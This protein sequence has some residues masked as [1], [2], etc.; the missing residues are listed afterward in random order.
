MINAIKNFIKSNPQDICIVSNDRGFR[1]ALSQM[2]C[3]KIFEQ[4]N[5]FLHYQQQLDER[6][7]ALMEYIACV[8]E[9]G[10]FDTIIKD[11]IEEFYI[12][13]CCY[14][15]WECEDVCVIAINNKLSYLDVTNDGVIAYIDVEADISVQISYRDEENS[16]YDKEEG[17]YLFE[18]YVTVCETHNI[19]TEIGINL[20]VEEKECLEIL[21]Y[22]IICED[23][24]PNINLDEESMLAYK[25][26]DTGEIVTCAECGKVKGRGSDSW[27][28][29]C[30]GNS[31]CTD[32][33]VGNSKGEIC[34]ICGRKY[35]VE[36]MMSGYCV[37]CYKN[38][39]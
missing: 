7:K 6:E 22:S 8:M 16:Y 12:N 29:D 11:Y 20:I 26:I 31:L 19:N 15:E 23:P 14:V 5:D 21:D 39:D 1:D 30:D 4:L 10:E 28:F 2:E 25:K 32:C 36:K 18:K 13:H 38:V 24:R 35:P 3:C 9:R 17:R 37:E 33:M 34:P 27:E